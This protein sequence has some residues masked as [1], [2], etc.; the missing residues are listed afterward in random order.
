MNLGRK[1]NFRSHRKTLSDLSRVF[2]C[3]FK[4]STV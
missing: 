2:L 3:I 4:P 1:K